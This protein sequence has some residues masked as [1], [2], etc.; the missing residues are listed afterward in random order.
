MELENDGES[1][2][3]GLILATLAHPMISSHSQLTTSSCFVFE[4]RVAEQQLNWQYNEQVA[5]WGHRP[6]A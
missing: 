5:K 1:D 2:K 3:H 4:Y 6:V